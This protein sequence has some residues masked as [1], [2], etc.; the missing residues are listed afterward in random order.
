MLVAC[1]KATTPSA[2][3]PEGPERRC[4]TGS[5]TVLACLERQPALH[6]ASRLVQ[7][8]VSL[9][10]GH[11]QLLEVSYSNSSHWSY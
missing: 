9:R 4:L 10:R 2:G 8:P 5:C 7:E 3:L 1:R 11:K 6:V